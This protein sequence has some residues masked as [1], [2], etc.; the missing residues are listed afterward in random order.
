MTAGTRVRIVAGPFAD[1]TGTVS[2]A[3]GEVIGPARTVIVKCDLP[4]R[5]VHGFWPYA[6]VRIEPHKLA[7]C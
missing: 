2:R 1:N 5:T 4:I 6:A 7:R 3:P